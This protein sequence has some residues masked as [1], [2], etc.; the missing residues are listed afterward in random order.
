MAWREVWQRT[1]GLFRGRRREDELADEIEQ[2]LAQL[3]AEHERRGL[4][5]HAARLAARREFGGVAQT[6]EAFRDQRHWPSIEALL[7]DVRFATRALI[8]DRGTTLAAIALL[9]IGVGTTVVMADVLDRVLLR[10]PEHVDRPDL[11]RRIYSQ[12]GA[13]DPG[14]FVSNYVTMDLLVAGLSR[15]VEVWGAFQNERIGLGRGASAMRLDTIA[16]TLKLPKDL[17]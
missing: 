13:W 12:S 3:A 16:C 15:E 11:A 6:R 1:L 5:P 10:P 4:S 8:K 17:G 2:H 7:Q 9:T 14:R